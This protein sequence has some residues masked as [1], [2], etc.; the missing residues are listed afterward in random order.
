MYDDS[1][2]DEFTQCA[3]AERDVE[4]F[5]PV[6]GLRVDE[7]LTPARLARAI[8]VSESS[9]KR[10]A[11]DGVLQAS[12]TVGGH[13]RIALSEAV[14]F[15]R[16]IGAVVVRPDLLGLDDLSTVSQT[17]ASQADVEQQVYAALEAGHAQRVRAMMQ[18]LYLGGWTLSSIFDGPIR[19]A[20]TKIGALWLHA[21]WGLV[22][23]HRA[24]TIAIQS[25]SQL[26]MLLPSP[27]PGAPVA[28][29]SAGETDVYML[30]SLMASV[31]LADAGYA[32]VNLG[33]MTPPSV[34]RNAAGFYK[35]RLSW[36]S[37]S[38]PTEPTRLAADLQQL[39]SDLRAVGTTLIVGGRMLRSIPASQL[40]G[41]NIVNT[42]AELHA[43]A[44]GMLKAGEAAPQREPGPTGG[45]GLAGG[46]GPVGGPN[47]MGDG[48]S[49][50]A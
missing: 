21:E 29:G 43:Y 1:R 10:W 36:V 14:R 25:I 49:G 26:R 13:R 40:T 6:K 47:P 2:F 16:Q 27:T 4:S 38:S 44:K 35:A 48:V 15:I 24:T 30:P 45:G 42:M 8:G 9:L 3:T 20:M 32:D 37:V 18:S 39:H 11:N 28:V 5:I 31:V 7:M 41:L 22:V 46:S 12:R 23:E 50:A 34:L 33:P 19:A 17:F